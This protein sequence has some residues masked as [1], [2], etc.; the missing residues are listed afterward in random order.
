MENRMKA[1]KPVHFPFRYRLEDASPPH[2]LTNGTV[3]DLSDR[4][5]RF[6]TL[7]KLPIGTRLKLV[8]D[9]NPSDQKKYNLDD[10]GIV[11]WSVQ[12][13]PQESLYRVGLKFLS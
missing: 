6:E 8:F 10:Q 3:V 9:G 11:V 2:E 7:E 5:I 1:R 13:N 4:G 12:P